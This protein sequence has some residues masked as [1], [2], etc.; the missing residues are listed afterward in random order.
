MAQYSSL[1]VAGGF[2]TKR[3]LDI[4]PLGCISVTPSEMIGP[5]FA[6]AEGLVA[7][8]AKEVET[9]PWLEVAEDVFPVQ[10]VHVYS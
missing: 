10:L 7:C 9:D 2:D 3:T 6:A 8:A 1:S 4:L 5:V